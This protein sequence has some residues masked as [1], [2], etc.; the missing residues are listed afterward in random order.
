[1]ARTQTGKESIDLK[2]VSAIWR[3]RVTQPAR[4][5]NDALVSLI[6]V[7]REDEKIGEALLAVLRQESFQRQSMLNTWIAQLNLEGAPAAFVG[8]LACLLDDGTADRA[9]TLLESR[10]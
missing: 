10:A 7:A 4:N 1:M 8:A 6:A 3:R 5:G 9:R 2:R